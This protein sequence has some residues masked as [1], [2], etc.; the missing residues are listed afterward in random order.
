M[1]TS[2]RSYYEERAEAEIE[3]AHQARHPAA[4]RAHYVLAAYYLDLAHNPETGDIV[5]VAAI[6]ALAPVAA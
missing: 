5:T 3:A 2:D 4:A 1:G 6:P